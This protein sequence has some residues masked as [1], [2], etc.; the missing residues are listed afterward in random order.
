MRKMLVLVG[1][2]LALAQAAVAATA[3]SVS[4]FGI[5]W[6]FDKAYEVGQ[7]V[8]GDWWVLGPVTI[9]SI[10]KPSN[11]AERDGSMINPIP[12]QS[13][14]YDGRVGGYVASLDVS[15]RI[16][17]L[18]VN[19]GSSLVSTIS[20]VPAELDRALRRPALEVAAVLTVLASA[21]P[22]GSFRPPYAGTTKTI[23]SSSNLQS[24]MLLSLAPVANTP[25]LASVE[26]MFEKPWIDNV[27]EWQGDDLHPYQNMINYGGGISRDAGD[28]VLRLLLNETPAQKQKLLIRYIQLG[29]DDYGLVANGG[30][31]GE[32]GGTIGVGRKIPIL[33]AGLMLDNATLKNVAKDFNTQAVFQ[34]DGQ[35]FYLTQAERTATYN[36][37]NCAAGADYC[38]NGYYDAQ[39]LGSPQWGERHY[40]WSCGGYNY[41]PG[42]I[43]YL[44]LTHKSTKGTALAVY[45]LGLKDSWN[46]NAFLDW[47]DQCVATGVTGT[48]GSSFAESMWTAYRST[49]DIMAAPTAPQRPVREIELAPNPMRDRTTI[50]V[51]TAGPGTRAEVTIYNSHG[52]LVYQA[53]KTEGRLS[54][55]WDGTTPTGERV[56]LGMY[57]YMVKSKAGSSSGNFIVLE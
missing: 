18:V 34:E 46:Y 52:Q 53:L 12:S 35:T 42:K 37:E 48:W 38:F 4:Q 31:W 47:S 21:P 54:V 26:A 28:G 36:P 14:G 6:T 43:A 57:F 16:P 56:R 9:T 51:S 29:I 45:L 25:S 23:Y 8:N 49:V 17:A 33:F 39:P 44:G 13:H 20:R 5:T 19:N 50:T 3:A 10:S 15:T 1:A 24:Q 41:L 30:N 22:A 11:M 27:L 32:V 7:F 2:L 55:E 40:R